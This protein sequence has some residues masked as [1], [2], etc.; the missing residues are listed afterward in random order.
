MVSKH[1]GHGQLGF[2]RMGIGQIV[3]HS[4]RKMGPEQIGLGQINHDTDHLTYKNQ[5]SMHL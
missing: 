2:G 3:S 4:I 1:L 5:D